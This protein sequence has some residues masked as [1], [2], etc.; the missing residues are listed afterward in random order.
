[1]LYV[2][3]RP[4]PQLMA[5]RTRS[6]LVRSFRAL[7]DGKPSSVS[8]SDLISSTQSQVGLV[9]A[10]DSHSILIAIAK[11]I[12]DPIRPIHPVRVA[13][14]AV[15]L[16][17]RILTSTGTPFRTKAGTFGLIGRLGIDWTS[18]LP[19]ATREAT[20]TRF[21]ETFKSECESG[22]GEPV[23]AQSLGFCC[24]TAN[25]LGL[26]SLELAGIVRHQL[27]A[28][29]RSIPALAIVQMAQFL[30]SYQ[31]DRKAWRAITERVIGDTGS[32]TPQNIV[33]IL[34]AMVQVGLTSHELIERVCHNIPART[35]MMRISDCASI[36]RSV[37][38][39]GTA[40][41]LTILG[42][43]ANALQRRL[44]VLVVTSP[45]RVAVDDIRQISS[46][47]RSLSISQSRPLASLISS[48]LGPIAPTSL[49]FHSRLAP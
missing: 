27:L 11:A 29:S 45:T 33:M 19:D 13:P 15:S 22:M 48:S 21:V 9:T 47:L 31:R 8:W 10:D 41:D 16:I 43:F 25:Q 42:A 28:D 5:A 44:T 24:E 1:M 7:A 26:H 18:H 3:L 46:D 38:L 37:A 49:Q 14:L 32:F 35:S 36:L 2:P 17:D 39:L 12:K 34:D 30:T 40:V 4:S 23:D 6:D 20:L